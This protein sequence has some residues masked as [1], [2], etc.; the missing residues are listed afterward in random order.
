MQPAL[1]VPSRIQSPPTGKK[2]KGEET[3][4][5]SEVFCSL[6]T[7]QTADRITINMARAVR[8]VKNVHAADFLTGGT[9]GLNSR[10]PVL[11]R[12]RGV[13]PGF[14]GFL[15]FRSLLLARRFLRV[16]NFNYI[17]RFLVFLSFLNVL[18]FLTI[19]SFQSLCD[20]RFRHESNCLIGLFRILNG[21][22]SETGGSHCKKCNDGE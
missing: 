21:F 10:R 12:S 5:F 20:F 8:S 11:I 7:V 6:T 2:R 13:G 14:F 9:A 17:Q 15:R 18:V 19:K 22:I 1:Q 4:R 16:R 3:S